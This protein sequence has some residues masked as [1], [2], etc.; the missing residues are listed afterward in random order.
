MRVQM[1]AKLLGASRR[2]YT[3]KDGVRKVFCEL[4][5]SV[6][7]I[8]SADAFGD[9]AQKAR[10]QDQRIFDALRNGPQGRAVLL[11]CDVRAYEGDLSVVVLDV[12]ELTKP[13][14]A[15]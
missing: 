3:A 9:D 10:L 8:Q 2:E 1:E 13:A 6:A 12:R 5:Y 4:S 11:D 15:A 14:K 7:Q